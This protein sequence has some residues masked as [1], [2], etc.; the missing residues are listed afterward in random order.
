VELQLTKKNKT[1]EEAQEIYY[2]IIILLKKTGKIP[3][4]NG[5]NFQL[6]PVVF[7]NLEYHIR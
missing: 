7:D 3:R 2:T 1:L 6:F 5:E 4:E